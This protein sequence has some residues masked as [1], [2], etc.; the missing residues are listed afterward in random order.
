[1]VNNDMKK[2]LYCAEEIQEEAIKCKH[3]QE[4]QKAAKNIPDEV[5]TKTIEAFFYAYKVIE[6]ASNN[7][8][9]LVRKHFNKI[10][11]LIILLTLVSVLIALYPTLKDLQKKREIKRLE[12][13]SLSQITGKYSLT[14][15][16]LNNKFA[17]Y[18]TNKLSYPASIAKPE[19]RKLLYSSTNPYGKK[20][21]DGTGT[22]VSIYGEVEIT[23]KRII[24]NLDRDL[25]GNFTRKEK[26]VIHINAIT[27][28]R[29]DDGRYFWHIKTNLDSGVVLSTS[30]SSNLLI[31]TIGNDTYRLW[32]K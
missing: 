16:S 32:L 28:E 26:R 3:C 12:E 17:Y 1:M 18:I 19:A 30:N 2:C 23:G 11:S 29:T 15:M 8:K 25:S 10:I 9:K 6:L 24:V 20:T 22:K 27:E 13:I 5:K 14:S 21:T 31:Y 4:M 7:I